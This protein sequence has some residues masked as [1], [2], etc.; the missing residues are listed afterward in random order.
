MKRGR[1]NGKLKDLANFL[2]G[3]NM[4]SF[5]AKSL[6]TLLTIEM[7]QSEINITIDIVEIS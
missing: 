7:K 4:Q 5:P 6:E 2:I 3:R 1:F